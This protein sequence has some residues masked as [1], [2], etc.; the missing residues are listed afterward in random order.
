M[1]FGRVNGMYSWRVGW[2]ADVLRRRNGDAIHPPPESPV[3]LEARVRI[4]ARTRSEASLLACGDKNVNT[5]V[6]SAD[7]TDSHAAA[8]WEWWQKTLGSPRFIAA[9]MIGQS[10]PAFRRLVMRYGSVGLCYSPMYLATEINSGMH[11]HNFDPN[12]CQSSYDRPLFIQLAG[13]DP[14]AMVAAALRVQQ[15]CDG[16]DVNLGCPQSCAEDGGYGAPFLES[17]PAGAVA[18]VT[19]L[20]NALDVPISIKMRLQPSKLLLPDR[21]NGD[22]ETN[23]ATVSETLGATAAWEASVGATIRV[24]RQLVAAGA[25]LVCLHGRYRTQRDHQVVIHESMWY[26]STRAPKRKNNTF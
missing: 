12:S 5:S 16:I 4:V 21:N 18:I 22:I 6:Q 10:D 8:A 24:G 1:S 13:S 11:D 2:R 14:V 20:Q 9:P 26:I 7:E 19:A 23:G 15:C 25:S 3:D 17:N